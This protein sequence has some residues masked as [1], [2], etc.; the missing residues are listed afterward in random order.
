MNDA[1]QKA[2]EG[3]A[4]DILNLSKQVME[5]SAVGVNPKT[6]K[7]TLIHSQMYQDIVGMDAKSLIAPSGDSIVL[8]ALFQNYS[9]YIESDRPRE[10]GKKPPIDSLRDWASARGISTDND[11]LWAISTAIWRDG[12]EG[13]PLMATLEAE[14]GQY[15]NNEGSQKLSDAL[16]DEITK[17]FN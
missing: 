14:I 3:I 7:N 8:D 2:I 1:L 10:Y 9:S 13:R 17:Y 16:I 15:M 12:H 5:S 4:S 11:T 6:G